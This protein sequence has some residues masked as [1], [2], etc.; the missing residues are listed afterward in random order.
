[1]N[2][3]SSH[4]LL[5]SSLLL[6]TSTTAHSRIELL[7]RLIDYAKQAGEHSLDLTSLLGDRSSSLFKALRLLCVD[8]D[9]NCRAQTLRT[10][11][12]VLQSTVSVQLFYHFSLDLFLIRALE[13]ESKYLWERLQAFKLYKKLFALAPHN[14][15]RALVQSILAIAEQPKDDFRRVSLDALRELMLTVPRL[16]CSCNGLRV[17]IDSILDPACSDIAASLT[18]T[19]VFLLDQPSTRQHLRPSLDLVRLLAVF[20][21][22]SAPDSP[23]REAR[24]L[25]AHRCVVTLMRTWPGILCLTHDNA[26]LSSLVQVL[27]LP[28]SV[29]GASW[30]REAVFD[31]LLEILSVIKAADVSALPNQHNLLHSYVT[32]ILLSFI[33]CGLIATLTSLSSSMDGEFRGI[34]TKLLVEILHLAAHLLPSSLC[35]QLNSLPSVMSAASSFADNEGGRV[36]ALGLITTLSDDANELSDGAH[37]PAHPFAAKRESVVNDI[38]TSS[39]ASVQHGLQLHRYMQA[40][41]FAEP[42][43]QRHSALLASLRQHMEHV[44]DDKELEASIK[45]TMIPQTKDFRLWDTQLI[46]HLLEGPLTSSANLLPALTKTKFIKRICSF[47]RPEKLMFSSLD[48]TPPHLIFVRIAVALFKVL[49]GCSEGRE[50]AYFVQLIDGIFEL[51][52]SEIGRGKEDKKGKEGGAHSTASTPSHAHHSNGASAAHAAFASSRL[53]LSVD[54]SEVNLVGGG[55]MSP[56]HPPAS[57]SRTLSRITRSKHKSSYRCLSRPNLPRKLSQAYFLLIGLLSSSRFGMSFFDK[58]GLY[59]HLYNLA[60]DHSK[61]YLTRQLILHLDY[62]ERTARTLL[63]TWVKGGSVHL[64]KFAVSFLRQLIRTHPADSQ[65]CIGMLVAQL[66]HHDASLRASVLSLLQEV[67]VDPAYLHLVVKKKPQ[68]AG[69]GPLGHIL[70]ALFVGSKQG[71]E[72]VQSNGMLPVL[73]KE[74]RDGCV[75]YVDSLER[76]LVSALSGE[77]GKER[78]REGSAAG[79]S[80]SGRGQGTNGGRRPAPREEKVEEKRGN[81]LQVDRGLAST[82]MQTSALTTASSSSLSSSGGSG[83]STRSAS[84]TPSS[85]PPSSPNPHSPPSSSSSPFFFFAPTPRTSLD[86]YFFSRAHSLPWTVELTAEWPNGRLLLLPTDCYLF[87]SPYELPSTSPSS[88]SDDPPPSI[89]PLRTYLTCSLL[90]SHGLPTPYRLDPSCTLRARISLGGGHSTRGFDTNDSRPSSAASS[91]LNTPTSQSRG[92][93]SPFR[94]PSSSPRGSHSPNL[95]PLPPLPAMS[96]HGG[97]GGGG[98]GGMGGMGVGGHVDPSHLDDREWLKTFFILPFPEHV[99][100]PGMRVKGAVDVAVSVAVAAGGG[101][102]EKGSG[103]AV[104]EGGAGGGGGSLRGG[105]WTS[106]KEED[107]CRWGF[108]LNPSTLPPAPRR[109]E[110][111]GGGEGVEHFEWLLEGLQFPIALPSDGVGNVCLARHLYGELAMTR[112]GVEVLRGSGHVTDLVRCV[113][114]AEEGWAEGM[115]GRGSEVGRSSLSSPV[116]S[117]HTPAAPRLPSAGSMPLSRNSSSSLPSPTSLPRVSTSSNLQRR[118]ALWALGHISASPL[119]FSLLLESDIVSFISHAAVHHPTL[120]FRGTCYYI[121]SLMARSAQ[122]RAVLATLGW[123]FSSNPLIATVTPADGPSNLSA[124]LRVKPTKFVG[125]WPQDTRNTYGIPSKHRPA[126]GGGAG[127]PSPTGVVGAV[128]GRA[129]SDAELDV[130][131]HISNLCNYVTQKNSLQSLRSMR[132]SSAFSGLFTSPQLLL[133]AMHMLS[134]YLFRLPARRF[135]LFDL[136][137][138]VQFTEQNLACFDGQTLEGDGGKAKEDDMG[139]DTT[140]AGRADGKPWPSPPMSTTRALTSTPPSRSRLTR[141]TLSTHA[142]PPHPHSTRSAHNSAGVQPPAAHPVAGERVTPPPPAESSGGGGKGKGSMSLGRD[143]SLSVPARGEAG[144]YRAREREDGS[145]SRGGEDSAGISGG[146]SGSSP[147]PHTS[148]SPSLGRDD[149]PRRANVGSLSHSPSLRP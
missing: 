64:R 7:L 33:D 147:S 46:L 140:T 23:D 55:S 124:F 69:C 113:M 111:A 88:D 110:R 126:A 136:F 45:R 100:K 44:M 142:L 87:S 122:G 51:V 114:E 96:E 43:A 29:K 109:V 48:Y 72:Y 89:H 61:D 121:L 1:M 67:A 66:T 6:S 102:G 94:T 145:G 57:H 104:A 132:S 112:E 60:N 40:T 77:E 146:S 71:L 70:L 2:D 141:P 53:T 129:Y 106:T 149:P 82:N 119:G 21:D 36:R 13:R 26:A 125:S 63:E 103:G 27:A 8:K 76:S 50:Y 98:G 17:L 107:R 101:G 68:L 14:L 86:D 11:R 116:S 3:I 37:E 91:T 118:A 16:V 78:E 137:G 39:S 133:D 31:L 90:D 15:S 49:L 144:S 54:D 128:G 127:V 81:S 4:I 143:R 148:S 25:A 92:L 5:L 83:Q 62:S 134:C 84:P 30:A 131:L 115:R 42:P 12:Y 108:T 75:R 47:L 22:T 20:T 9:P 99:C 19:L 59:D 105:M 74:W 32:V 10:L 35:S 85:P 34:A 135:L 38:F 117:P 130:L 18:L 56:R 28:V 97:G 95:P 120:S 93:A 65:W 80:G 24:R 41:D 73:M 139:K 79:G 58:F 52:L 123:A 138:A